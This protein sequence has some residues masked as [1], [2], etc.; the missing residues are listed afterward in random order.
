MDDIIVVNGDNVS[1]VNVWVTDYHLV[2]KKTD[3]LDLLHQAKYHTDKAVYN[4]FKM[5]R[6]CSNTTK[7]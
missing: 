6:L 7:L 3:R 1:I 4:V 2:C 5:S